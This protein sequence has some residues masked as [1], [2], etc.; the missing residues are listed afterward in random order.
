M[1]ERRTVV[2]IFVE[3]VDDVLS[4]CCGRLAIETNKLVAIF[5]TESL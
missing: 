5:D 4:S 2:G 3:P 1:Y